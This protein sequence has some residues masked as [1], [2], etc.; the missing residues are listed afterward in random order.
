MKAPKTSALIY[1]PI[2]YKPSGIPITPQ[3]R[4]DLVYTKGL[5]MHLKE[6]GWFDPSKIAAA[7][8]YRKSFMTLVYYI[9]RIRRTNPEP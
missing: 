6:F 3:L 2:L 9:C 5:E 8:R 7:E 4:T 1:V